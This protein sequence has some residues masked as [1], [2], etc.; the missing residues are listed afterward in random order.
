MGAAVTSNTNN[1]AFTFL[2]TAGVNAGKY[3]LVHGNS[4]QLTSVSDADLTTWSSGQIVPNTAGAGSHSFRVLAGPNAGK[5][6]VLF[7]STTT[8]AFYT[9]ASDAFGWSIALSASAR[10]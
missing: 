6:L 7:N 8:T 9:D 2:I 4:S 5:L 3:M 10:T 1:G